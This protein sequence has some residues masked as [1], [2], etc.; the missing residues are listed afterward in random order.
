MA[1]EIIK[2]EDMYHGMIL[3]VRQDTI[4]LPKRDPNDAER[5]AKR[6][7][8]LHR[9]AAAVLPVDGDGKIIFVRQY[10][11]PIGGMALEIPAGILEEGEEPEAGAARELEEE[12]GKRA[13]K[14]TPAFK[15]YTSI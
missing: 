1:Y 7:I 5:V 12:T 9:P 13:G 15:C 4:T 3:R 14:L 10:R 8:V 6:E 2:S 11:H